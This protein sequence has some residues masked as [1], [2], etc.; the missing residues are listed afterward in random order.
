MLFLGVIFV[1]AVSF[2][3]TI[4]SF[5]MALISCFFLDSENFAGWWI[6]NWIILFIMF[7][8]II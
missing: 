7:M 5:S 2:I 6:I 4:L 8:V 1:V 3:I